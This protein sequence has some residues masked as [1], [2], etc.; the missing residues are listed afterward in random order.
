MSSER[1]C[2]SFLL[3]FCEAVEVWPETLVKSGW[4]SKSKKDFVQ[5]YGSFT[6]MIAAK[7]IASLQHVQFLEGS[8][9]EFDVS[10]LD[11]C[12]RLKSIFNWQAGKPRTTFKPL[13]MLNSN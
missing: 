4:H 2:V 3:L 12:F 13:L 11:S 10:C 5:I 1:R 9:C 7:R 6:V 8:S